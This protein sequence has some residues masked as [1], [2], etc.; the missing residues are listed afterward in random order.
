MASTYTMVGYGSQ[1][2]S[3]RR[4]QSELN[5]Q[6]YQLDEDGV[7][8]EKTRAAVR[9]Y[10]KKN[11]L[12]RD[13]IAGDET[14]GSLMSASASAAEEPQASVPKAAPTARTAKALAELEAGY[15]PSESVKEALAHRDSVASQRPGDY[16][17]LYEQQYTQLYTQRGR[18]AMEDTMGQAAVLTGGYGSSYAQGA[19]QQAYSRYMQELMALLPEFED[20]ARSAYQQEGNDLRARYDLLD[21]REQNAYG[22]WQDDVSLWEK[23]LA[24]AQEE[25]D[26]ASAED[27][28]LYETM[29]GHYRSKAQQEQKLSASGAEVSDGLPYGGASGPSGA[30]GSSGSGSGSSGESLSSVA[31]AS[32]HR[33]V[34]S[35]LRQGKL[36]EAKALLASYKD[37]MTPMQKRQFT[38]MLQGYDETAS[39]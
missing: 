37:R 1:G 17:S 22:R 25:Y 11:S 34:A 8:G 24:L 29:L 32:L 30:S 13:G 39:L 7:F 27:R 14:W 16:E 12:K 31:A 35:Y 20:R 38:L 15:K 5:K 23:R 3:V 18:A 2:E 10:Q 6:G 19:G 21:Q 28:K 33:T 9:D 36:A 26:N 4:L